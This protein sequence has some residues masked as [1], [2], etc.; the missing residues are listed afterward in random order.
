MSEMAVLAILADREPV[1]PARRKKRNLAINLVN[2][3]VSARRTV[4]PGRQD[5]GRYIFRSLPRLAL[6]FAAA[7]KAGFEQ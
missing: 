7:A 4:F 1:H 3:S 5:A 6:V 2:M